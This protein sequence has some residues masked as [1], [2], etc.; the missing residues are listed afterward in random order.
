MVDM[1]HR[2]ADLVVVHMAE[3]SGDACSDAPAAACPPRSCGVT[4]TTPRVA[5]H[6]AFG[7]G[8]EHRPA[9]AGRR[10][11]DGGPAAGAFPV[12]SKI[13]R[14]RRL[15]FVQKRL[16]AGREH[17]P[18][19]RSERV[20]E[21]AQGRP[22]S[23]FGREVGKGGDG[24]GLVLGRIGDDGFEPRRQGVPP[25]RGGED[26]LVGRGKGGLRFR[27]NAVLRLVERGLGGFPEGFGAPV[28]AFLQKDRRAFQIVEGGLQ[29]AAVAGEPRVR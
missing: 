13:A 4:T 17:E 11:G 15:P 29:L 9:A 5:Q 6:E 7:D 23:G 3:Q 19:V 10:G 28:G 27:P 24:V 12:A 14:A 8:Q 26:E 22:R 2:V 25:F 20:E 1:D 16:R 18:D 21:G